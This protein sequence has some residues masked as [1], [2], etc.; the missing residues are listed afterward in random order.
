M[1]IFFYAICLFLC[2]F[3]V[4]TMF[5][6]NATNK[7]KIKKDTLR[8][9]PKKFKKKKPLKNILDLKWMNV[10]S[11]D[12]PHSEWMNRWGIDLYFLKLGRMI[13]TNSYNVYHVHVYDLVST[14]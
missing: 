9:I 12:L 8:N 14:R 3:Y 13:Y 7:K 2:Y 6:E 4:I 1:F 11:R 10:T 5:Q